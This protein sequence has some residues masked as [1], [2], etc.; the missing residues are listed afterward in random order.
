MITVLI[1]L[2]LRRERQE[3]QLLKIILSYTE[4]L[5]LAWVA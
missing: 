2:A 3:D 4:S 5:R 1:T